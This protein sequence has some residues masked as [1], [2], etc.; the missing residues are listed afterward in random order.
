MTDLHVYSFTAQVRLHSILIR[1]SP[2]SSAPQTLK[3]YIN[4][5]DVDFDTA[6][7]LPPT[8]TFSLSQT[9][10]VQEV[11]V[12]RALF[13]T[14]RSLD[15]FFED[16]WSADQEDVTRISY[17]G[18]KGEWMALNREAVSFLYEAAAN[19][20]DHKMVSGVK[21]GIGSTLGAA[22]GRDGL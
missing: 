20:S 2:S 4:R 18:F 6:S 14:T 9:S 8:Q 11:S 15:L 12:K 13:N 1:T 7:S 16:N 10:D 19:P 5:D 22:G 21:G 3:V 17:I